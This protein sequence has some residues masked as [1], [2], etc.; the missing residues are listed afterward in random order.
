MRGIAVEIVAGHLPLYVDRIIVGPG[1]AAV[2]GYMVTVLLGDCSATASLERQVRI[3]AH[4]ICR[5]CTL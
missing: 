1:C 5:V 4:V 2:L 3:Y